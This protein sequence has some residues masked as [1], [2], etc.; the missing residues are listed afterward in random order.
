MSAEAFPARLTDWASRD[1]SRRSRDQAARAGA[2]DAGLLRLGVFVPV[3]RLGRL[4][5]PL[6]LYFV[7]AALAP[8]SFWL[9]HVPGV[10][11]QM[12][13][14]ADLAACGY[15]A[16]RAVQHGLRPMLLIWCL[17]NYAWLGVGPIYQLSHDVMAWGDV[18]SF[19][20]PDRVSYALVLD[21]AAMLA[22]LLGSF[23]K[24]HA[25]AVREVSVRPRAPFLLAGACV[26]LTPYAMAVNGGLAGLFSSREA[27]GALLAQSGVAVSLNGGVTVALAS[28]LPASLA[29]ASAHLFL[30]RLR[31]R[32]LSEAPASVV[33]GFLLALGLCFLFANPLTNTRFLSVSVFGSLLFAALRPRRTRAGLLLTAIGLIGLL[34][35]YPLANTFRSSTGTYKTGLAAFGGDDFDGFQQVVNSVT[36]VKDTG[37]HLGQHVISA[38]FYFVPRSMWSGKATPAAIEV[39]QHRGYAFTNLSLPVNAELYV[40]FG[41]VGMIVCF[42]LLGRLW[43]RL[44]AEWLSGSGRPLLLVPFLAVAQFGIIRGPLGS[45]A[46]VWITTSVLLLLGTKSTA[47]MAESS[48]RNKIC[49]QAGRRAEIVVGEASVS[50]R[51]SGGVAGAASAG[52]G[53]PGS[54]PGAGR[55]R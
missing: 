34:G 47:P 48:L 24:P 52:G 3:R 17:F 15:G 39:A 20:A 4:R 42:F 6:A 16:A 46:P 18:P 55:A 8:L 22:V 37:L 43:R 45:L 32:P 5:Q 54:G 41:L 35:L 50:S 1:A 53:D 19:Q 25:R 13:L 7:L 38:L 11:N 14:I 30:A 26:V 9:W 31:E 29:A 21:L 49:S 33:H 10:A 40:E 28:I 2:S 27:R 12:L 44:D 23:G 51:G 36:Y